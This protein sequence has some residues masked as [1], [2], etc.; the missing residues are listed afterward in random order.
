MLIAV[1]EE[2]STSTLKVSEGEREEYIVTRHSNFKPAL[3]VI[4]LYGKQESRQSAED[5]RK[6]W[7]DVLNEI[8]KIESKK[9]HFLLLG[10]LNRHIGNN[11]I[12]KNHTKET[13]A[14]K[15]LNDLLERDS[16]TLVNATEK[17]I[18]GPFT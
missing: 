1:S 8:I 14:G 10:D 11:L 3:N 18:N 2:F 7:E 4:N 15:L 5:I 16:V 13:L 17:T 6:G 12:P 9:E